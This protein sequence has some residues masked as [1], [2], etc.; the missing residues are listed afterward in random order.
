VQAAELPEI[1]L[2]R[3]GEGW[4]GQV[5]FVS[6]YDYSSFVE[7]FSALFLCWDETLLMVVQVK[8][9]QFCY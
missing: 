5:P 9:F 6:S 3:R 8:A 7:V 2:R 1:L 4:R